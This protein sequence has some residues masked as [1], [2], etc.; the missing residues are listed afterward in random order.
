[1]P[2]EPSRAYALNEPARRSMGRFV[3]LKSCPFRYW[4]TVANAEFAPITVPA[5]RPARPQDSL[6][7]GRLRVFGHL[8]KRSFTGNLLVCNFEA[9]A[10]RTRF[11]FPDRCSQ[12]L[13]S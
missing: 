5:A 8:I 4:R 9:G 1:M 6:R 12:V 11:G 10:R 7:R 2:T 3:L 13:K